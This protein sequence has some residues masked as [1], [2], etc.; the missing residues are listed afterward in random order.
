ML[1]PKGQGKVGKGFSPYTNCVF[2]GSRTHP[3]K[4]SS[5]NTRYGL[6]YLA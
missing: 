5:G 3:S 6:K 4:P 1:L 2:F